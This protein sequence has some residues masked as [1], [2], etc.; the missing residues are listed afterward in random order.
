MGINATISLRVAGT[1]F[2]TNDLGSPK[3]P[4]ELVETQEFTPGTGNDQANLVFADTRTIA[5]SSSE[6]LDLAGGLT[7]A[8]GAAITFAKVR[9]IVVRAA[10]ANTNNVVVGGA[11]SNAFTG[12]FADATDKINVPPGGEVLLT[13]PNAGWTVTASTGDLLKVANSSSGSTVSYD[14]III[15]C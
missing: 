9:A 4:F 3:F 14:I 2:G 15:G 6:D 1:E 8:F 13:A 5:A 10:E 11:A 12:P 7:S